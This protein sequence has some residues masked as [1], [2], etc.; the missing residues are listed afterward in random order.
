MSSLRD[1]LG[2]RRP[3]PPLDLDPWLEDVSVE[4]PHDL[5]LTNAGRAALRRAMAHPGRVRENA[6]HLLAADALLTYACEAA[7]ESDDPEAALLRSL[8]AGL[9]R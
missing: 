9:E 4:G 7:L 2:S 3:R 6:F 8:E 1:W 5:V